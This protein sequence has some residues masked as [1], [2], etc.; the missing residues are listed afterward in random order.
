M[1]CPRLNRSTRSHTIG[2]MVESMTIK[3]LNVSSGH[4]LVGDDNDDEDEDDEPFASNDEIEINSDGTKTKSDNTAYNYL[5]QM[6]SRTKDGHP[7][8]LCFRT[9]MNCS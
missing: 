4:P 1:G 9:V 2:A 7:K 6:Y 3:G 5:V 8:P